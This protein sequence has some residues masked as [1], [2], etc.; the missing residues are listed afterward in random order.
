MNRQPIELS[1]V[2]RLA[3]TGAPDLLAAMQALIDQGEPY[4]EDLPEGAMTLDTL[5]SA[6]Q[7]AASAWDKRERQQ[8]A[9]DAWQR[10][11]AQQDDMIAPQA[12]L[13]ELVV[14]LYERG[15]TDGAARRSLLVI[16]SEAPL[17]MGIW[18]GIKRV[19]KRAEGDMD[20]EVIGAIGARVDAEAAAG[21]R[22]DAV[23]R[24]TLIYM[25]RRCWRFLRHLGKAVP[26][27]YP[28]FAVEVLRNYP[29]HVSFGAV[30]IA[31]HVFM[32]DAKKHTST[33]FWGAPPKDMLKHRAY[34]DAWKRSPDPLMLLLETCQ[35]DPPAKFAIDGLRKDFPD[36]LRKVTPEWLGR[37][38][39]RPLESA[40]DFLVETLEGSPDFHQGKLKGLGLHDAVLALLVSPSKKAR[41]YAIEYARGHAADMSV[42]KL[43]ELAA[44]DHDDTVK[45]AVTVLKGKK[46]RDIGVV[47]LG[48]L[49]V[50]SE[51]SDW[52]KKAL[53]NEFDR[54]EIPEDFLIDMLYSDESDQSDWAQSFLEKKFKPRE[55]PIAF[56]I[57]VLD[58]KR[59][60]DSYGVDDVALEALSKFKVSELPAE[61]LIKALAHDSYGYQV[62][63]WMEK[64]DALPQG[65]DLERVKGM[66]FNPQ[67]RGVAF[68]ILG[69]TKLVPPASV[70]IGWLL[71]LARRADPAL[72]EWAHKY[73][74]QHMKPEQ[75]A[76]GKESLEAGVTRLFALTTGAKEPEAVRAFAQKY[77]RCH[78][79]KLSKQQA[80]AKSLGVKPA[81]T[82]EAFSEERVWPCLN[83]P[84][85]DVRRFAIDFVK[86]ELRK[87]KAQTRVYELGESAFKEVR[88]LCYEVLGSVGDA[89]ADPDFSIKPD[90]LD[91]AQ[92]FTMTESRKRSTRDVAMEVI[93]RQYGRI[94][95]AERLGWLMQSADRE[96][97]LFA[98]R[99]LWE[100]HRPRALP[101]GWRPSKGSIEDAGRFEDVQALR[102]LL[103]R[104]LFMVPPAR[105]ME[106]ADVRARRLPASVA[107]RHVVEIV[108]DLGVSDPAFAQLVAPVLGE[109]SGSMA[110][111][112]W[113]A[114]LQAL[115]QLRAAHADLNVEGMV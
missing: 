108:R 106:A 115:M 100:K 4:R 32:H 83:D 7:Q 20:A 110:K 80:D 89:S 33:S 68:N 9:R 60:E 58:D 11:L 103:R 51:T 14:K 21:G 71:A 73:L 84:R 34:P 54:K 49:L 94:G 87:W 35:A 64:A 81:L 24:G 18:G 10:Y 92:V 38:S 82:R 62:G 27:L 96:V 39:H 72:H 113:H 53:E 77:L 104:L 5:R 36:V 69:N 37:L 76:D 91:A 22:R 74:L 109:F 78:H 44:C 88:N 102:A 65:L 16:L 56:W 23:A 86:L 98:V 28:Q 95:G 99:L 41:T 90:E 55:L 85:A 43:A 26:E 66:V 42:E 114:C 45:F 17:A 57:K 93:R 46:P 97:R 31:N 61:W 19:Y 12:R 6:L 111:G 30:W 29:R 8:R 3:D 59:F 47:L 107:K 40:H 2:Q 50:P 79:P 48:R 1:D 101:K 15:A 67:Q 112:E 52:A 105:A 25:R 75:F 13:A 63:E 70:G